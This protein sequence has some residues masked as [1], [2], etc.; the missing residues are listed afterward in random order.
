MSDFANFLQPGEIFPLMFFGLLGIIG[1]TI[2][3]S[4]MVL[5]HLRGLREKHLASTLV[6]D[7]LD[8][9]MSADD[10]SK[11]ILAWNSSSPEAVEKLIQEQHTKA[12]TK[13]R[14]PKLKSAG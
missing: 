1:G 7:M 13:P 11:I 2:A 5:A 14:K 6:E 4:A 10:I 12:I 8:R 9:N 3:I